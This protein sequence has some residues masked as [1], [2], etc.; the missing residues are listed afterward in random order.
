MGVG[1]EDERFPNG[2]G[3]VPLS[4]SSYREYMSLFL[5]ENIVVWCV[6][7]TVVCCG[8]VYLILWCVVCVLGTVDRANDICQS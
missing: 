4:S 1:P 5:L 3:G 7:D 2:D 8:I 6:V